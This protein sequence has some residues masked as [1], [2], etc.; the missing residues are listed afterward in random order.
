MTSP[1]RLFDTEV[2]RTRRLTPGMLRLTLGGSD[3]AGFVN[4]GL[5]QR[6]KFLL[7]CPG[8]TAA[9]LPDRTPD[10]WYQAWRQLPDEQ[11][12]VLRTYT[13]R[14]QRP[15]AREIDVDV[16]LHRP[17]IASAWVA[18]ARP[19]DRLGVFGPARPGAGG[20]EFAL[21]PRA[22]WVL[23]WGDQTALPAIACVL[24]E[25]P[26]DFPVRAVVT[27][28]DPAERQHLATRARLRLTWR[29]GGEGAELLPR[30]WAEG[31]EPGAGYAWI[32]G[33]AAE[34]RALRRELLA[35]HGFQRP[36]ITFMGY[37]RRGHQ[38]G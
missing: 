32:A 34:I 14:A 12:P 7:P 2:L 16:A 3:L 26:E 19:G 25:L 36:D 13:V 4:G 17:G 29:H 28:P 24:A 18:E 6:I 21:P 31:L 37:W 10:G 30:G 8:R 1:F 9:V 5:D 20:V 11:R 33:E 35:E 22:E 38:G 23:L 15:E 27:V